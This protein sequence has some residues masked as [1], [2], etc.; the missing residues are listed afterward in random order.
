LHHQTI[1]AL[2]ATGRCR[3]F[4]ADAD[5][6]VRGEGVGM[7]MLKPLAQSLADQDAI[8]GTI[9]ASAVNHGGKSQGFTVPNPYSQ[10]Q[11][12]KKA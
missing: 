10:A 7:L 8:Y 2:S 1:G 4:S 5:G 9:I 3:T 6:F 11:L 12:L